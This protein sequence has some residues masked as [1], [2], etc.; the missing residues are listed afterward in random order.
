ML[1]FPITFNFGGQ[2]FSLHGIFEF[3]AFF[4]AFRYYLLLRRKSRD[5]ISSNNRVWIIIGAI[6]GSIVGSRLIG[7]LE[8][9]NQLQIAD[10]KL[11]YFYLNK[12]VL[13]GFLGGLFGVELVKKIIKEKNSSGDLFTYPMILGLIIGRLGCFSMGVFEETYGTVTHF[14]TGMDLGDHQLRHPVV[15]YEIFFLIALWIG[16]VQYEKRKKLPNGERFK[17]FMV[18]Y[19]GFRFL[20]D[21]IKPHYT[22]SIGLSTIQITAIVGIGYYLWIYFLNRKRLLED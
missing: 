19:M 14:I 6:F 2:Q 21:F 9:I 7:G 8:D 11:L 4:V 13:G 18:A 10:S 12:T 17:I 15:L 20:L 3:L 16:L 5:A 22:W 1:H